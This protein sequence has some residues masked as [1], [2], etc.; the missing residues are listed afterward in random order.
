[1]LPPP[2]R[3][4]QLCP[5]RLPGEFCKPSFSLLTKAVCK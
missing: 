2:C 5:E 1:M 3:P 4:P